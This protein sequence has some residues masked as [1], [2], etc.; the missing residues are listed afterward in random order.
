MNKK[1]IILTSLSVP[2]ILAASVSS[3]SAANMMG[4]ESDTRGGYD[5]GTIVNTSVVQDNS[6]DSEVTFY[7]RSTATT[8]SDVQSIT[9]APSQTINATGLAA[10][11]SVPPSVSLSLTDQSATFNWE[12][13]TYYGEASVEYNIPRYTIDVGNNAVINSASFSDQASFNF[14]SASYSLLTQGSTTHPF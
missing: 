11:I 12:A 6:Y 8:L 4:S 3:A 14:G 13:E 5:M 1:K 2:L 9:I 10:S 7:G